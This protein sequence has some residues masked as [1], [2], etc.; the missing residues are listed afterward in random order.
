MKKG[1]L[2][3]SALLLLLALSACKQ[4]EAEIVINPED[5]FQ[6][7]ISADPIPGDL[8]WETN[9]EDEI[10]SS[11]RAVKG[12]SITYGIQSFPLTASLF[13]EG[14]SLSRNSLSI[15]LPEKSV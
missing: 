4:G 15:M 9:L 7:P 14:K 8:I 5:I 13:Q 6:A 12:G 10:F 11:D 2:V 1:M 3:L